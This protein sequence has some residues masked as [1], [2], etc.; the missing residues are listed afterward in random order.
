MHRPWHRS[1]FDGALHASIFGRF[2]EF[3][4]TGEMGFA[5]AILEPLPRLKS[6]GD[7]TLSP[8][9]SGDDGNGHH[10]RAHFAHHRSHRRYS[11]PDH[12]TAVESGRGDLPDLRRFDRI[13]SAEMAAPIGA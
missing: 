2:C 8:T 12:A 4:G 1:P 7:S 6:P 13:G 11:H 5:S 9:W 10:Q 3:A